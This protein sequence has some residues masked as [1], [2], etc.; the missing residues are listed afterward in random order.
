[1]TR[2]R[3]LRQGVR[4]E[5]R[6]LEHLGAGADRLAVPQPPSI[7]DAD[8][9]RRHSLCDVIRAE[10]LEE[11]HGRADLLATFPHRRRRRVFVVVHESARQAPQAVARLDRAPAKDDSAFG[12]DHHRRRHLGVA[13]EHEVVVGTGLDLATFDDLDDQLRAAVD[14]EVTHQA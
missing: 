9:R 10:Q 4:P 1:V 2:K 5:D 14:A 3:D 7:G 13:P 12:F 6:N 11:L 8:D